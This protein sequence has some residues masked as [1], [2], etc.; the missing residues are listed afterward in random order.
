MQCRTVL[1]RLDAMRTGELAS[2]ECT[3]I[4]SH[5]KKCASCEDSRSDLQS[6]ASSVRELVAAPPRSCVETVCSAVAQRLDRVEAGGLAAWVVFSS[7][8][9]RRI[10]IARISEEE[11]RE[12]YL[13]ETGRELRREALPEKWARE[14]TASMEGRGGMTELDLEELTEFE[15]GVLETLTKVPRGEVRSYAWLARQ[16]GRPR[17]IRAVGNVMARNPVPLIVPCHRVV[18][19]GGG[20]GKYGFGSEMKRQLLEREGVAV[21]ELDELARRGVRYI[22]SKTT[23]IFCFPTCRDAKRIRKE[24]RVGFRN[25]DDADAKGFRPCLRCRPAA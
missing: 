14:I 24:N 19:S 9:V 21:D 3:T 18:P 13:S 10:S 12:K 5:L 4:E 8:G 20:V 25:E 22:G 16:A 1:T 6:F 23:K 7:R 11:F 2:G 17:A 15:R